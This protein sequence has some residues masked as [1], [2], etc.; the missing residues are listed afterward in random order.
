MPFKRQDAK[1]DKIERVGE[2][3]PAQGLLEKQPAPEGTHLM[4]NAIS[5]ARSVKIATL[6][7]AAFMICVAAPAFGADSA[8]NEAAK[9]MGSVA[10]L[11]GV[12]VT[13]TVFL[14]KKESAASTARFLKA[15][16]STHKSI[17]NQGVQSDLVIVFLGPAVQYLSTEPDAELAK[18]NADSL[19]SVA[20]TAAELKEMGVRMEVCGAATKHFGV[21]NATILEEMDVVDNGFISLIGWQ[22]Q[23]HVPMTF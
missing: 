4:T 10:A 12:E 13:K 20:E 18:E 19:Q 11:D 23:G 9:T 5:Q 3:K 7:L 15:I 22:S 8:K 1:V 16:R 17:L 2:T 6:L 21:D 14:V